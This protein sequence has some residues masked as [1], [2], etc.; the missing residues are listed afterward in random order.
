MVSD[1][2]FAYNK[3]NLKVYLTK[4]DLQMNLISIENKNKNIEENMGKWF[5]ALG[6]AKKDFL[7]SMIP[8]N[9]QM[10]Y[11]RTVWLKPIQFY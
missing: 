10:I 5:L 6:I 3:K 2:L 11:H 1:T 8:K 4:Q 9:V 7:K